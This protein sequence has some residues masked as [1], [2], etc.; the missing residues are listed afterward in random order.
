[1]TFRHVAQCLNQLGHL[2]PLVR[3][4][5]FKICFP[6]NVWCSYLVYAWGSDYGDLIFRYLKG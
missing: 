6:K 4:G 3:D 5:A 1:M 2:V